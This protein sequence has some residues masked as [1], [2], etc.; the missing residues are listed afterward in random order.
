MAIGANLTVGVAT[1]A[2]MVMGAVLVS[3]AV[4]GQSLSSPSMVG[5]WWYSLMGVAHG[6]ASF[7]GLRWRWG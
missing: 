1:L 5:T 3:V 2:G 6:E 7:E 4:Y